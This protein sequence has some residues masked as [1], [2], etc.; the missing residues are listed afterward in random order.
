MTKTKTMGGFSLLIAI[1][2]ISFNLR[3]PITSIGSLA[4]LIHDE[5]HV[6]N[7]FIGFVTTLPLLAFS[8]CSPFVFKI[9]DKFGMGVTIAGS[10]LATIL[11]GTIRSFTG[12][13]GLVVGTA[14]IGI[15]IAIGN[16][17]I[18]SIV[19]LKFPNKIGM[20]T[21]LYITFQGLFAAIGAGISYPLAVN[22]QLGWKYSLFIWVIVA[23]I[24]LFMWIPQIGIKIDSPNNFSTDPHKNELDSVLNENPSN[25]LRLNS[26][27]LLKSPLAWAITIFMGAQ[28]LCFYSITAWLPSILITKGLTAEA[29]GYMAFWYQ[30][31]GLPASF[32]IPIIATKI[33]AKQVSIVVI[34]CA[35]YFLGIIALAISQSGF[36]IMIAMIL[37]STGGGA[38]F[39][40]VVLMIGLKSKH[41]QEVAQLSGMSQSFGYLLAAIG[42]T[43]AGVLYDVSGTWTLTIGFLLI[44]VAVMLTAGLKVTRMEVL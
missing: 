41:A 18:P 27:T 23:T 26:L 16:V 3:A 9:S 22:Y 39:A 24:A 10:I 25:S 19:K 2:F 17:L 7:G 32:F 14:L 15:G 44:V 33:N 37:T 29:S 1:I 5:L 12:I 8:F 40:W 35:S 4:G 34:S 21:S 13:I 42:P 30:L 43:L 36:S 11:G 28:S 31:V 38:T 6:T 20:L